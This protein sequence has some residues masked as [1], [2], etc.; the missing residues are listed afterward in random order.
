MAEQVTISLELLDTVYRTL[1]YYA[2]VTT[3]QAPRIGGVLA[4][5][6]RGEKPTPDQLTREAR[7]V[8]EM[9]DA[10]NAARGVSIPDSD[11]KPATDTD[12]K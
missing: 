12:R 11:I 1:N 7:E 6:P 10:W 2:S 4:G 3:Y 8:I 5:C 9:L